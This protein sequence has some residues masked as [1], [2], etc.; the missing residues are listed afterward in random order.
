MIKRIGKTT[1]NHMRGMYLIDSA[2]DL[3]PPL[4]LLLFILVV[5]G[6]EFPIVG[7]LLLGF[8]DEFSFGRV[9]DDELSLNGEL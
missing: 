1:T 3:P 5:K 7:L 6:V 4:L 9:V 8:G 2:A